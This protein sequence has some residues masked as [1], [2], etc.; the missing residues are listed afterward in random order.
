MH[1]EQTRP[2]DRAV[3]NSGPKND[4]QMQPVPMLLGKSR[5]IGFGLH[6]VVAIAEP[7]ALGQPVTWVSTGKAGIKACDIT[8]GCCPTLVGQRFKAAW[9]LA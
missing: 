1:I 8:T 3:Q 4:L 9:H 2:R 7:P 6:H 5:L